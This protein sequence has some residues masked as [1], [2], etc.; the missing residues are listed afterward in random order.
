MTLDVNVQYMGESPRRYGIGRG[1][2]N[3]GTAFR[4][5]GC[6]EHAMNALC[7]LNRNVPLAFK[8]LSYTT[9]MGLSVKLKVY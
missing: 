8:V 7:K 2:S 6:P 4:D 1:T 5:L 9:F 3:L